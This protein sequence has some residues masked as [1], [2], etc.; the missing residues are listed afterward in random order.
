M[1]FGLP[2]DLQNRAAAAEQWARSVFAG[3]PRST[4]F[5]AKSWRALG[6]SDLFRIA[7]PVSAGGEGLGALALTAVLEAL[8]RGGA[9]RGLLMAAGA[10]LFG[11]ML[12]LATHAT[13]EQAARWLSALRDGEVIGALA[14]TEPGGGSGFNQMTTTATAT[15]DGILLSGRKSLVCNAS[16][17]G[18]FLVLAKQFP[19]R[20][21]MG[22]TTFLVPRDA[23]GVSVAA[24]TT[25]AGLPGA[26]MG[27][28]VL[29]GCSLPENAT[30]GRPGA[31]LR[32][33][34]TAMKWE[35]CGLLAGFV[36][37][38]ERD[39]THC[40]DALLS[41]GD[42][43]A[44]RHQAVMHRMARMKVRLE[45]A[46]LM[47]RRAACSI[48][49]GHDDHATSAMAKY[50]VSE[51]LV[52]CAQDVAR[53]LAGAGWRGTPFDTGAALVDALGGLFASG[54]SEIQLDLIARSV[55][56]EARSQ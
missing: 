44:L 43:A 4:K 42:G 16:H 3:R 23:A 27:E 12:P 56:A 31:G 49:A 17:A 20:G 47:L 19:D 34:M 52:D 28:L 9:D 7:L 15:P 37:A 11:C 39:L 1:T 46:R 8:G 40:V 53:L 38:A 50:V 6:H 48:D 51:A 36:G 14:V 24:M 32:V 18:V 29:D 41:R 5:D 35:R 22:L 2:Q 26:A 55:L 21:A 54:T 13:P 10:H 25:V 30:L 45:S 33:F